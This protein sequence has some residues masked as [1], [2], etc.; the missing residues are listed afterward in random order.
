MT[1]Y[2]QRIPRAQRRRPGD[3]ARSGPEPR[4]RLSTCCSSA[5]TCNRCSRLLRAYNRMSQLS[6]EELS[7]GVIA[8]SAG[9]HAQGVALSAGQL[10]AAR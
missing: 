5:R 9:N 8:S 3:P 4:R 10:A 2:L 1:D 7:R 6:Q